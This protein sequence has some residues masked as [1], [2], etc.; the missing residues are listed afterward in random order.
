MLAWTRGVT[1]IPRQ[2]DRWLVGIQPSARWLVIG[3]LVSLNGFLF[4]ALHLMF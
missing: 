1:G 3:F 4:S 2:I